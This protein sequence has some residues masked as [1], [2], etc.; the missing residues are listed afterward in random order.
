MSEQLQL[1]LQWR[2]ILLELL[3]CIG[4]EL[5]VDKQL[6]RFL[7]VLMRK[8]GCRGVAVFELDLVLYQEYSLIKQVPRNSHMETYVDYLGKGELEDGQVL[9]KEGDTNIYAYTLEGFGVIC[10][11]H[12]MLPLIFQ[13][14]MRQLC[15]K[16]SYAL[17]GCKQYQ[18]L[19]QSQR[20]LDRFFE[21]SDNLMCIINAKGMLIKVNPSFV[22]KLR[23][24]L[25]DLYTTPFVD[26]FH[27]DDHPHHH[28]ITSLLAGLKERTAFTSRFRQG[29]GSYIDL[30]WEIA[31]DIDT[32]FFYA[33]AMDVT[34]Q[35]QLAQALEKA[36]ITAEQTAD[37]KSAFL[38]NMSHE[39]R[40][41]LNGVL[42]MLDLAMQHPLSSEAKHQLD[43]AVKSGKN[44]LAIV[45]DVL[46]FSKI[47]E[48]KLQL[49]HIDFNPVQLVKDTLASFHY[50]AEQKNLYLNQLVNISADVWLRGDPHRIQQILTNLMSNALKFTKHG[51]VV[52]EANLYI[53]QR[54]P[55][56]DIR[57]KDTGIGLSSKNQQQLFQAFSQ[58][59][60]STTRLYG[61]TGLGLAICAELATLMQGTISVQSEEHQ[62]A[63]F[64][65][66]LP[67]AEGEV[68]HTIEPEQEEWST[69]ALQMIRAL[70]VEDNEINRQIAKAMLSSLGVVACY[71][72]N[73][74]EAIACLKSAAIDEFTI[75]LMDCLMPVMDGY[76]ATKRIRRGEAGSHWQT[77]PI[78]ALTANAMA[79]DRERCI[80]A[81][82]SDYLSK[83]FTKHDLAQHM[84]RLVRSKTEPDHREAKEQAVHVDTATHRSTTLSKALSP[85]NKEQTEALWW[86][87]EVF[88]HNFNG[89]DDLSATVIELFI[90]HLPKTEQ[91]ITAAIALH[92]E[93]KLRLLA[94]SLKS[95]AAQVGCMK[96]SQD[97]TQLEQAIVQ[98][99]TDEVP[100]LVTNL[101]AS[102]HKTL[103]I[104][105]KQ[106]R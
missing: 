41:P 27:S 9:A 6:Q 86:Q 57:V 23:H 51:G 44:L 55:L 83:P 91:A 47:S 99:C 75:V 80:A 3:L 26:F 77:I 21:L 96:L 12:E 30:A 71:A 97:A 66:C 14:E 25:D 31:I 61:G 20:E 78:I 52:V 39:I 92:D 1:Q 7:P 72:V 19:K 67:L 24:S 95:S 5:D 16:L 17:R 11:K 93:Q 45:N 70:V 84:V 87:P 22:D 15:Q 4:H 34:L 60:D 85:S 48:G 81:G 106:A 102:L 73:G 37:A 89:M 94:H 10:L 13:H 74:Q 32:Q 62:G 63:T 40:T 43:T 35:V 38:A 88:T 18:Q 104:L 100:D 46:D 53:R 33:S 101:L 90:E 49:E 50:L 82:M 36:K 42:G 68:N 58:A 29:D 64:V 65:V 69:T 79:E 56:L 59:N 2:D 98:L 54:Q 8:L 105:Q 103:D 76:E 28:P